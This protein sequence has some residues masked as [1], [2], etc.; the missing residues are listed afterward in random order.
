MHG[1]GPNQGREIEEG[2]LKRISQEEPS[3]RPHIE[4]FL[5]QARQRGSLLEERG[6][7]FR[8]VHL[9]FQEFLAVRHL[10]E[11]LGGEGRQAMLDALEPRLDAPW[12]R[13]PILLLAGYLG[14]NYPQEARKFIDALAQ[15]GDNADRRFAAAELAGLAA[16][17]WKD[18]GGALQAACANR[19]VELLSDQAALAQSKPALRA[20]AGDR[21]AALGDPRFDSQ[22]HF[23]PDEPNLGFVRI[24]ADPEFR[25]GTRRADRL[26]VKAMIGNDVGDNEINDATTPTR[27]FYIAR[28][29]SPSPNSALSS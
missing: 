12:W 24:P 11:V 19:I 9:A 15:T 18:G 20:L 3:F 27:E 26:R 8:F 23:L 7:A 13:K 17:E 5:Q 1:Q 10:R 21:L 2:T 22:R 6:G 16:L 29:P 25:I 14:A 4:T 28:D